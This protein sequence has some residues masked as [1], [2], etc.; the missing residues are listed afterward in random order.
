MPGLPFAPAI[1]FVHVNTLTTVLFE[2][3]NV[4]VIFPL[5]VPPRSDAFA[6]DNSILPAAGAG[7]AVLVLSV[8]PV[9]NVPTVQVVAV[10]VMPTYPVKGIVMGVALAGL[11]DE[12]QAIDCVSYPK[13]TESPPEPAEPVAPLSPLAPS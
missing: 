9:G 2:M 5:K 10:C 1:D 6:T 4:N 11:L 8:I 7:A 12:F 3:V 13:I